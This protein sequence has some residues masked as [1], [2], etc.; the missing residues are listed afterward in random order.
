MLNITIKQPKTTGNRCGHSPKNPRFFVP[1][2]HHKLRPGILLKFR[3]CAQAYYV[4]PS[5]FPG[6]NAINGSKRQQRSERREACVAMAECIAHYTDL[7]TMRVGIPQ[8]NGTIRNLTMGFLAEKAGLNFRRAER[9]IRDLKAAGFIK[10]QSICRK[11]GDNAYKSLAAVRTVSVK[12]FHALGLGG[13]LKSQ[14][15]YAKARRAEKTGAYN[16]KT[17]KQSS[18]HAFMVMQGQHGRKAN[19]APSDGL[20]PFASFVKS[21]KMATAADTS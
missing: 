12:L 4:K 15:D 9:A 2:P 19:T 17:A 13:W 8:P 6:L 14:R 21:A 20:K 11:V 16:E 1:P 7:P 10:V 18:L 3:G 5:V